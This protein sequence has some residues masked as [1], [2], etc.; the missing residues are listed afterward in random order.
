MSE[1]QVIVTWYAPEEKLPPEGEATVVTVSGHSRN[2]T[3]DHALMTAEF[4]KDD[5][6]C[7][8]E[9]DFDPGLKGSWL[10]IHAWSDLEPYKGE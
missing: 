9:I 2:I 1:R 4:Y 6:W 7:L 3:L 5:G 8:L 10:T